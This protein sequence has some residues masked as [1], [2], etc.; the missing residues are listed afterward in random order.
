MLDIVYQI[1]SLPFIRLMNF[2]L[3]LS[4]RQP[5]I[6]I[7]GIEPALNSVQF[8]STYIKTIA[9]MLDSPCLIGII[10]KPTFFEC[11]RI[12]YIIMCLSYCC[13]KD[14]SIVN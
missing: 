7:G 10:C 12:N 13:D 4:E 5:I 6:V 11:P 1:K 8:I 3:K 2:K 9:G 14:S